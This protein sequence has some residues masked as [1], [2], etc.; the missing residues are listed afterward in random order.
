MKFEFYQPQEFVFEYNDFGNYFYI[1]IDGTCSVQSPQ[2]K[3]LVANEAPKSK[4]SI[5]GLQDLVLKRT[6]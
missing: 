4:I 3:K 1:I 6:K 5:T 2:E